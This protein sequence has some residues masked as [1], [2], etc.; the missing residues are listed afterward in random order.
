MREGIKRREIMSTETKSRKATDYSASAVNLV[1]PPEVL[2]A[3]LRFR[4]MQTDIDNLDATLHAY[5][6]YEQ[7]IVMQQEMATLRKEAQELIE[8][9]GSYQD[10]EKGWYGIKQRA[11]SKSYNA[12]AFKL[13]YPQFT[14]AVIIETVNEKALQGLIKGNLLT[15][16]DLK[17]RGI[18]QETE[19]YR[20]IIK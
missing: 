16:T 13:T 3:I 2:D 5:P 4:A 6:E 19:S 20:F 12:Q 1:N 18:T 15:D 11:V 9:Y 10:L 7:M 8:K 14:P 17:T